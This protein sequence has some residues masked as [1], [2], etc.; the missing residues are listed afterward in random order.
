MIQN[1]GREQVVWCGHEPY[2]LT[3][4]G[5]AFELW[6]LNA[7]YCLYMDQMSI[8]NRVLKMHG[9]INIIIWK[10]LFLWVPFLLTLDYKQPSF[11]ELKVSRI[12]GHWDAGGTFNWSAWRSTRECGWGLGRMLSRIWKPG[13][14]PEVWWHPTS[15]EPPGWN[16]PST[17]CECHKSRRCMRSRTR[18]YGVSGPGDGRF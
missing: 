2:C 17:S 8:E 1:T 9:E 6:R 16:K 18:E 11:S 14:R 13:H 10:N 12:Q 3:S 7:V 15:C 4:F 5:S